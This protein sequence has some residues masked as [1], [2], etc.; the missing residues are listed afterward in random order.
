MRRVSLVALSAV[1][2]FAGSCEKASNSDGGSPDGGKIL[3]SEG[4]TPIGSNS[5]AGSPDLGKILAKGVRLVGEVLYPGQNQSCTRFEGP[6]DR[7][8]GFVRPGSRAPSELWVVNV[9]EI[10]RGKDVKCDGT[11]AACL[12]LSGNASGEYSGFQGDTLLVAEG[13]SSYG[14]GTLRAWR[15]GWG[16]TR[17]LT[18]SGGVGCEIMG[19]SG[20]I[21]C[22]EDAS[23]SS[24]TRLMR[25]GKVDPEDGPLLPVLNVQAK[26]VRLSPGGQYVILDDSEIIY[27]SS[28]SWTLTPGALQ[29]APLSDPTNPRLIAPLAWYHAVSPDDRYA[30]YLVTNTNTGMVETSTLDLYV[31]DLPAGSPRKL[32]TGIAVA[33]VTPV[34]TSAGDAGVL[35]L[36]SLAP[37]T[38]QT[39]GNNTIGTLEWIR[40]DGRRVMLSNDATMPFGSADICVDTGSIVAARGESLFVGKLDGSFQCSVAGHNWWGFVPGID[41]FVWEKEDTLFVTK[42]EGRCM[43]RSLGDN[44][45]S[46]LPVYGEGV[47]LYNSREVQWL[48]MRAGS[49]ADVQIKTMA[50]YVNQFDYESTARVLVYIEQVSGA[51]PWDPG[52][53]RAL[54]NPF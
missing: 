2:G 52:P 41:A 8:C 12:M 26:S 19:Q 43:G 38:L 39:L 53:L 37:P 34:I 17:Q 13:V 30:Y 42:L 47:V 11:D 10:S 3:G 46:W 29:L 25:A 49:L 6:G 31:V 9:S 32:A 45:V 44:I 14:A 4:P 23:A 27:R 48:D 50:N 7:W 33:K 36:S 15:P 28:I 22:W 35:V 18:G 40:N 16:K 54:L 21:W 1:A 51:M 24:S 20:V 5:D